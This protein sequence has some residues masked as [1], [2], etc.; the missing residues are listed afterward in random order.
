MIAMVGGDPCM[1]DEAFQTQR[2]L[3]VT[4][5]VDAC[6]WYYDTPGII[7]VCLPPSLL[8]DYL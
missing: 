4:D 3:D 6:I 5:L 2:F 1:L 8:F 7:K